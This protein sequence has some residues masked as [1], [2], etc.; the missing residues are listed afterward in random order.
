MDGVVEHCAS[1]Y[2]AIVCSAEMLDGEPV[3]GYVEPA[4]YF[5]LQIEWWMGGREWQRFL[6][7]AR[8]D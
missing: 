1:W 3:P 8:T 7:A 6:S 2:E 4:E 5:N